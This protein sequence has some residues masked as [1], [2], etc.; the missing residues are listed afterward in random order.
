MGNYC[1]FS[2]VSSWKP[3][4]KVVSLFCCYHCHP[5]NVSLCKNEL[6][7][8]NICIKTNQ[9]RTWNNPNY[10][11]K[12]C[13]LS[14]IVRNRCICSHEIILTHPWL[15]DTTS[16]THGYRTQSRICVCVSSNWNLHQNPMQYP[17]LLNKW[18]L[19]VWINRKTWDDCMY[20]AISNIVYLGVSLCI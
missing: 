20:C 19:A 10:T 8:F 15:S 18:T 16:Y 7:R 14:L 9:H 12:W 13:T 17:H 2:G 11:Y 5:M 3:I 6:R 4:V 1:G